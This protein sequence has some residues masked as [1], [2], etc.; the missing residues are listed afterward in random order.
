MNLFALPCMRR[1]W[2]WPHRIAVGLVVL[3]WCRPVVC[4]EI[5]DAAKKGDLERVQTLIKA[6]PDLVSSK[7]DTGETPLYK[8]AASGHKDVAYLLLE[9]KADPNARNNDGLTPLHVAARLGQKDVVDLLLTSKADVDSKDSEG[10]TPLFYAAV[11]GQEDAAELLVANKA[12][13]MS[14]NN[15]GQT[16]LHFAA[17]SG[18]IEIARLLLANNAEVN[19]KDA[20]GG[21][22]LRYSAAYGHK[23]MT[24]FLRQQGAVEDVTEAERNGDKRAEAAIMLAV[25]SDT[26]E[27]VKEML[28]DNPSLANANLKGQIPV[29]DKIVING[30]DVS[31]NSDFT[32]LLIAAQSCRKGMVELLLANKADV[33]CKDGLGDT[34]LHIAILGC[35][36]ETK[37][38]VVALLESGADVNGKDSLGRTPL[39]LAAAQ[40]NASVVEALVAKGADVNEKGVSG[41]TPL[42]S[43]KGHKDVEEILRQHGA[44][45]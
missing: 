9:N 17:I 5:H 7:D 18:K 4:G 33:T 2:P 23:R 19:A 43:A 1:T 16:P 26:L 25:K 30:V 20:G 35:K 24:T 31:R 27:K 34:P 22:P 29:A 39:Q 28:Q 36:Q 10:Q 21:T 40:G 12:D 38:M 45:K 42:Q 44:H 8:A 15:K 32:P 6:N 13:V 11:A 3:L 37:E 14:R 41:K